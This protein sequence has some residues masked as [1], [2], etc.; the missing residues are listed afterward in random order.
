MAEDTSKATIV[1]LLP[2][3]INENKGAGLSPGHFIIPAAPKNG[4][5]VLVVGD[6]KYHIYI[7]SDRGSLEQV[8]TALKMAESIVQDY[9][10]SIPFGQGVGKPGLFFVPGPLSVEDVKKYHAKKL[11]QYQKSN[12]E[13]MNVLIKLSD[14]EWSKNRQRQAIPDICRYSA[15][16]L[17]LDREWARDAVVEETKACKF[18]TSPIAVSAIICPNC[19]QILDMQAFKEA[20]GGAGIGA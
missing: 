16:A 2:W 18:C 5:S 7:D 17:G 9:I 13:W 10:K 14:D 4:L 15:H 1:S 11:E 12:K 3:E 8:E 19:R 6:S 20:G